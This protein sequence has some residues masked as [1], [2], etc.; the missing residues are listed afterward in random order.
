[1]RHPVESRDS[2]GTIRLQPYLTTLLEIL[3]LLVLV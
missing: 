3:A 2:G 1:L